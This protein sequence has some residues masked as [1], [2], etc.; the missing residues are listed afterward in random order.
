MLIEHIKAILDNVDI[1]V[2]ELSLQK[3]RNNES[4]IDKSLND[5]FSKLIRRE[6]A[7]HTHQGLTEKQRKQV[8]ERDEYKCNTVALI[9]KKVSTLQQLTML[10]P[11][12]QEVSI[13]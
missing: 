5:K 7:K 12:D 2:Y 11:L 13:T 10:Y 6:Y 9:L 4:Q 8:L 3:K 1:S